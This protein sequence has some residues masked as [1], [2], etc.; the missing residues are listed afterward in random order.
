[1]TITNVSMCILQLFAGIK[2]ACFPDY[3]DPQSTA[4]R[5]TECNKTYFVWA[6][7]VCTKRN[8]MEFGM[9]CVCPH[10]FLSCMFVFNT[11]GKKGL[12]ALSYCVS[13]FSF[14]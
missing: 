3:S 14:T 11:S 6:F 8:G 7:F 13:F 1:M 5:L 12:L 4:Q 10:Y 9:Q 2:P